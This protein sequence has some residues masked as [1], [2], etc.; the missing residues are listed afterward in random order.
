M[1]ELKAALKILLADVFVVYF[2]AHSYHWNVEGSNFSEYHRFFGELYE[3]LQGAID[4]TAEELR[5]CGEYAPI[6]LENL[7]SFKTIEEDSDQP[8]NAKQMFGRLTAANDQL[9]ETLNKVFTTAS[10]ANEQGVADYAAGRID[11]HKK[12]GWMLRSFMKGE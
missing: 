10:S 8:T 6:S 9:I 11:A 2:K 1:D 12:H 7:Y 5:A 4:T 3:D